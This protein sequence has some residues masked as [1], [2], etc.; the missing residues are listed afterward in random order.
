MAHAQ[1][2]EEAEPLGIDDRVAS[3]V[4]LPFAEAP[5]DCAT[6]FMRFMDIPETARV[7]A[8]AYRVLRPGGFLQCSLAP[9]CCETPHRRHLRDEHG[10]TDAS[11]VGADFRPR[12]GE[13]AEWRFGAAPPHVTQGLSQCKMPRR[14]RT[15]RQGLHV[16]VDTGFLLE[17][18]EEPRPSDAT[19]LACP[20][21]Q[22]PQIVADVLHSRVR[23]P[24]E[25]TRSLASAAN[26]A[27]E[28]TA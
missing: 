19:V 28:P 27:L 6:G 22:D 4:A 20:N 2:A 26:K 23:K 3:A 17:R 9:P 24:K 11:E 7:L 8:E 12:D 25:A 13:R 5:L 14:R 21:L 10:R 15:M 18:M 1:Q 16:L